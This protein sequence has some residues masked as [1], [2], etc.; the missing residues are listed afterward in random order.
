MWRRLLVASDTSLAEPHEIV[1]RA[2]GWGDEHLHRFV[3][4]GIAYG[5]SRLG[6]IAFYFV[7]GKR[8]ANRASSNSWGQAFRLPSRRL[9][10]HIAR[11]KGRSF[12]ERENAIDIQARGRVGA[13]PRFCCPSRAAAHPISKRR[14]DL[15]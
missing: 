6:G 4:Q 10:G 13:R 5:V 2:S 12:A 1:Q 3:I 8:S 11:D 7:C 9:A 14:P 15:E